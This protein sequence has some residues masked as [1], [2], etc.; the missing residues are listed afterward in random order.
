[1]SEFDELNKDQE[2]KFL[3][4]ASGMLFFSI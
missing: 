4:Y 1:L 3:N 2:V